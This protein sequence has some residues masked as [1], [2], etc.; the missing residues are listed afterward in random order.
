MG[1]EPYA[2][3]RRWKQFKGYLEAVPGVERVVWQ[4]A[5][6]S[7]RN[8]GHYYCEQNL[9]VYSLIAGPGSASP[10]IEFELT[11]HQHMQDP[12][13]EPTLTAMFKD[14]PHGLIGEAWRILLVAP[15]GDARGPDTS[16]RTTHHVLACA[17]RRSC[18]HLVRQV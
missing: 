16:L 1:D 3:S 2:D 12:H 15:P 8:V 13:V 17:W 7:Q 6:A 14:P 18:P 11:R 4:T 9:L 10:P 5:K